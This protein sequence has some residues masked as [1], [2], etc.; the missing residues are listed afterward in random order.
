[1]ETIESVAELRY[2]LDT[3]LIDPEQHAIA[4]AAAAAA[5]AAVLAA[6]PRRGH[7]VQTVDALGL[8]LQDQQLLQLQQQQQALL[9]Q[10][11][12]PQVQQQQEAVLEQATAPQVQQQG[13]EVVRSSVVPAAG[14]QT[15]DAAARTAL[16]ADSRID[17]AALNVQVL[18]QMLLQEGQARQQAQQLASQLQQQV[19]DLLQQQLNATKLFDEQLQ[20]A[21][22][23][24]AAEVQVAQQVSK[25]HLPVCFH[26][27]ACWG[28][29]DRPVALCGCL[30][31]V[32]CSFEAVVA[33]VLSLSQV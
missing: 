22:A 26:Y 11:T 25:V 14:E 10:Q 12:A 23:N 5:A 29:E 2:S 24:A 20:Q 6:S 31:H 18:Q 7:T 8:Q 17:P 32:S 16:P 30:K 1:M 33:F 27:R 21:R 3:T 15:A 9:M 4:Q 13:V 19:H 28:E